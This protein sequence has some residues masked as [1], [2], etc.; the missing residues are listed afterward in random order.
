MTTVT[1]NL[2]HPQ[3]LEGSA[4]GAALS[5]D[6]LDALRTVRDWIQD[7]I[8]VPNDRLG[9]P[10][11]VCPF[12]PVSIERQVLWLAAEHLGD[13]DVPRLVEL[14]EGYKRK[15]LE[16]APADG[17]GGDVGVIVVVL[18]D[19]SPD[20]APALFS[21]ALEQ[22]A[23]PS[24]VDDGILFGPFYDGHKGTAIYNEEFRPFQSPV[25]FLFVRHTV[26]DDWKFFLGSD[27]MLGH[28]A[29]RFGE[30][31]TRTLAAEL[32]RLPWDA[33]KH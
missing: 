26:L 9:R 30:S 24:L 1:T 11:P 19:V 14:L 25:P 6:D 31:A 15:L 27:D 3:D 8:V 23:V 29:R 18:T 2:L 16:L 13:G 5:A 17:D 22:I 28:W 4:S 21:G 12:T 7:F 33:P 32:R 20:Q 10:G